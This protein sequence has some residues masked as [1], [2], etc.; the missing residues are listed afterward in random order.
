MKRFPLAAALL[1]A[2][3]VMLFFSTNLF[4]AD[5]G[6][7]ISV[8]QPGFYGRLDI[9]GYP[10]P[11]VIYPEPKFFGWVPMNRPPI[12]MWVPR[13]HARHWREHCGKYNACN[14]R[15]FFVR[16]SWYRNQY[17]PYYW[18]RQRDYRNYD[19]DNYFYGDYDDYHNHDS[20]YPKW[21]G[22]RGEHWNNGH[23]NNN[24]H[25]HGRGH[26]R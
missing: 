11:Q 16:R 5:V 1:A 22:E 8:G 6:V 2:V 21:H 14:E 9:G 26:D 23:G 10:Q 20:H 4:A 15:V 18:E 19:Y 7:S 13:N 25:G 3:T 12:Y 24:W 17:V